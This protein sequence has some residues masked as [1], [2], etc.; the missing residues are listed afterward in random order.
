[1]TE[2]PIAA[3]RF[4]ISIEGVQ[5]AS[6]SELQGIST[7]VDVAP[8]SRGLLAHELTHTVQQSVGKK[9]VTIRFSKLE[10]SGFMS[11]YR[12]RTLAG[13]QIKLTGYSKTGASVFAITGVVGEVG[14]DVLQQEWSITY[15]AI[16]RVL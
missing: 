4:E 12:Q 10:D 16:Q 3:T 1:M 9:D 11:K 14:N 7:S 2:L 5:I 6:F 8:K 15:E 13:S